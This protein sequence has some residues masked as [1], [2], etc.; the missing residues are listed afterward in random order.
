[1][2]C[3]ALVLAATLSCIAGCSMVQVR[4]DMDLDVSPSHRLCNEPFRGWPGIHKSAML[5]GRPPG[6]IVT[7]S[8]S[9]PSKSLRRRV[10]GSWALGHSIPRQLASASGWSRSGRRRSHP[11]DAFDSAVAETHWTDVMQGLIGIE[12]TDP[13]SGLRGI[14][15]GGWTAAVWRTTK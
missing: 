7:L 3:D 1:M 2:R 11:I 10:F 4:P 15:I 9:R 5:W 14:R 13:V 8:P 6:E 12:T